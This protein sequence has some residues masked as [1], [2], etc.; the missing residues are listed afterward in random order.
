MQLLI[1]PDTFKGSLSA[2]EAARVM[3]RACLA[4]LGNCVPVVRPISDG[5]EGTL[6]LLELLG[7]GRKEVFSTLDPLGRRM[8]AAV[9]VLKGGELA[10]VELSQASGLTLLRPYERDPGLA[11]TF[12]TGVL[13]HE[14]M[15]RGVMDIIVSLGGSATNDGGAG[16]LS[17]LGYK[18]LD[19]DGKP[20]MPV[21]QQLIHIKEI[22]PPKKP[23]QRLNL[24]VACDVENPLCGP[25]GAV[26]VYAT[27]KGASEEQLETLERGLEHW[28]RLLETYSGKPVAEIPGTGAAGG[29]AAGLV[30]VLGAKLVPGFQL[31]SEWM[32]LD[33]VLEEA[34][35]VIT[36]E[37]SLDAQ[38]F[39]GKGP[40][41]LARKAKEK[42]IPVMA[43]AGRV[44]ADAK[45]LEEVGIIR[46]VQ[47]RPPD[48]SVE[49]C[50]AE[51]G[52]FLFEAVLTALSER[53]WER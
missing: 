48:V 25:N 10:W 4:S 20:V 8:D 42:G 52:D 28:G 37:G 36:G 9:V 6:D 5:G 12:G 17:A 19:R 13:L 34:D 29:T 45:E 41:E 51:A 33:K 3:Q 35:L 15:S 26:R 47:I 46:A 50:M 14:L 24:T 23:L 32:E 18:F 21:G 44:A 40:V 53:A 2:V 27:Q 16:L 31:I 30:G 43:F 11:N 39:M 7:L 1:A 22:V 38:S 49:Q